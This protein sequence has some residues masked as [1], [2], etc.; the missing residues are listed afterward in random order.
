MRNKQSTEQPTE[1]PMEN[2]NPFHRAPRPPRRPYFKP[3]WEIEEQQKK[4]A[5]EEIRKQA[6]RGLERTEE[7]FPA[8]V[9]GP[10]KQ[11]SWSGR[12]FNE[13]ASEW[14]EDADREKEIADREKEAEVIYAKRADDAPFVL[15]R[16]H[17]IRRFA[18]PEEELFEPRPTQKSDNP[19]DSDGGVW[20]TVL[21]KIRKEKRELTFE[22][23]DAKYA[24]ESGE[25]D[26]G[27]VWG[28]P[29]EHETCWDGYHPDSRR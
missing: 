3:Q 25:E 23:L 19:D 7:N 21:P 4:A 15:P 13:L 9:S 14:K 11:T 2:R 29:E 26:D 18:E 24:A 27:T 20:E 22:E 5:D 28:A 10:V 17:N 16:F 6:E 12:K 8:L 1:Q